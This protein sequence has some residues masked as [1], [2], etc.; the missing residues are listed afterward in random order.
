[1]AEYRLWLNNGATEEPTLAFLRCVCQ[2]KVGTV[3][4]KED[5]QALTMV[6]D[7]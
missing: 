6:I 4:P 5:Y 7:M 1:M 3:A 2:G